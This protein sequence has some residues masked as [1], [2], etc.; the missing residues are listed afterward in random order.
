MMIRDDGDQLTNPGT[1]RNLGRQFFVGEVTELNLRIVIILI[2]LAEL[3]RISA[4]DVLSDP[5]YHF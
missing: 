1:P 2:L 3:S 5:R 4:V